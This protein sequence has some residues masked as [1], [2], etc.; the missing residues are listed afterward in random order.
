[1]DTALGI[2]LLSTTVNVTSVL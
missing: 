2:L 1:M